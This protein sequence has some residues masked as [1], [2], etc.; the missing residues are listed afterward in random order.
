MKIFA[1]S[2]SLLFLLGAIAC[3]RRTDATLSAATPRPVTTPS[4]EK[5]GAFE[6]AGEKVDQGLH[7]TG[8]GLDKAGNKIEEGFEKAGEKLK[9]D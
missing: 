7:K 6:K 2:L 4:P 3:E 1:L 5:K 8:E 9:G